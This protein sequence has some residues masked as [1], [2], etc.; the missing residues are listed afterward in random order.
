MGNTNNKYQA[1]SG[2]IEVHPKCRVCK[3]PLSTEKNIFYC[4]NKKCLNRNL[5][6]KPWTQMHYD[7]DYI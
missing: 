6:G 5:P 4:S 2:G 7:L 3:N 1:P